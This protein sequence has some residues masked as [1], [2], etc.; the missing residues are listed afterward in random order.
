LVIDG[1]PVRV[2]LGDRK[3]NPGRIRDLIE[4]R[5]VTTTALRTTLDDV[6]GHDSAGN[7][8]QLVVPPPEG[9]EGRAHSQ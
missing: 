8:V 1:G 4:K 9:M 5:V 6:P 3:P 2:D 7:G